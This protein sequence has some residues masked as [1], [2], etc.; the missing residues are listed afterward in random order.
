MTEKNLDPAVLAG[1]TATERWF[2][3][4]VKGVLYT[5]GVHY[6]AETAG[7]ALAD[8]RDCLCPTVRFLS[9]Q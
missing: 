1:F 2:R 3:T 4:L 9:C 6:V 8:R 7:G 5:E